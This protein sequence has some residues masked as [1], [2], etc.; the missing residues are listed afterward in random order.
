MIGFEMRKSC[1]SR[2]ASD[3]AK[4][5]GA[6]SWPVCTFS[7]SNK[8]IRWKTLGRSYKNCMA[9]L[10]LNQQH[11]CH[12]TKV[13]KIM[14][15]YQIR[16]AWHYWVNGARALLHQW[17]R[18]ARVAKARG[19]QLHRTLI[20]ALRTTVW[21]CWDFTYATG[22]HSY[23]FTETSSTSTSKNLTRKMKTAKF[24]TIR[25]YVH[26]VTKSMSVSF[27]QYDAT[28]PVLN[29]HIPLKHWDIESF[30]K[31]KFLLLVFALIATKAWLANRNR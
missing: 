5:A 20:Y 31:E 4:L 9:R 12:V 25:V 11:A 18:Q 7:A 6:S 19:T 22:H 17:A 30:I 1:Y 3:A 8:W 10:V 29:T 26:W 23:K 21:N 14:E 15:N 2:Q 13:R 28:C 16:S 27:G 24:A